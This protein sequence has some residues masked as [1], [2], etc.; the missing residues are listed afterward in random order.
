MR[1]GVS[2]GAGLAEEGGERPVP[3]KMSSRDPLPALALGPGLPLTPVGCHMSRRPAGPG[4]ESVTSDDN[5]S[6]KFL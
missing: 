3:E 4:E 1:A 2:R 6:S 5:V